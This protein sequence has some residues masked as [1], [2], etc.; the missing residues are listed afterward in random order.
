MPPAPS[1]SED[2]SQNTTKSSAPGMSIPCTY[3]NRIVR[4]SRG[5]ISASFSYCSVRNLLGRVPL[6]RGFWPPDELIER[7]QERP[8]SFDAAEL[9]AA[10]VYRSISDAWSAQ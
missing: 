6:E 3:L 1:P 7:D 10:P 2:E 4:G 5:H 8:H 9:V